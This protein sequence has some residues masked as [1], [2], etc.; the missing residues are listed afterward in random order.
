MNISSINIYPVKSLGLIELDKI[1]A[2]SR[3]LEFDRRWMLIDKYG[4]FVS[5]RE[6]PEMCLVDC[7]LVKEGISI[8]Y[9]NKDIL[10]PF[11]LYDERMVSVSV[12]GSEFN[13]NLVHDKLD[14]WFSEALGQD[15]RLVKMTDQVYREKTLI[16]APFKSTVSFADGYPILVLGTASMDYLNNQLD[17][18]ININRFR[19]NIIVDTKIEHEEDNWETFSIGFSLFFKYK[20]LR[21]V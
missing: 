21:E 16:K 6:I 3:G 10:I 15:L 4:R 13:A 19:A 12:W 8:Q 2:K 17:E 18:K 9:N 7:G 5:Q 1:N 14:I 20:T 11:D